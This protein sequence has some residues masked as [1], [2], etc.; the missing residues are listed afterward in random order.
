MHIR[1][2]LPK[3]FYQLIKRKLKNLSIKAKSR[4]NILTAW[5]ALQE[6]G[7]SAGRASMSLEVSRA[8]CFAGRNV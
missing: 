8:P 5:Q 7:W 6:A 2:H 3:E 4:L 1:Y